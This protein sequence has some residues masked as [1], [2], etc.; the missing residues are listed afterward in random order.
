[1]TCVVAIST[2]LLLCAGVIIYQRHVIRQ[3]R[4]SACARAEE[5]LTGFTTV[6]GYQLPAPTH[7]GWRLVGAE[8]HNGALY[9]APGGYLY[10]NGAPVFDHGSDNERKYCA[11][12]RR[13]VIS[14]FIIQG[15]T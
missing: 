4:Q 9:I 5:T 3:L 11:A 1:V 8:L 12:V 6:N 10:V 14:S 7:S 13:A 15:S 2:A